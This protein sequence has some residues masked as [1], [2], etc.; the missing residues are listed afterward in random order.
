MATS[1]NYPR[2]TTNKSSGPSSGY[3]GLVRIRSA[4]RLAVIYLAVI[5]VVP[6]S[7][8]LASPFD[9]RPEPS[10]DIEFIG[11]P[12]KAFKFSEVQRYGL[13]DGAITFLKD[14]D[15]ARVWMPTGDGGNSIEVVTDDFRHF[16]ATT[17]PAPWVLSPVPGTFESD[18]TGISKVVRLPTGRLAAIYQA[19]EHPCGPQVAGVSIALATSDDDGRTW[20]RRG[21]IITSPP[22]SRIA[23]D[24]MV[25]HGVWSFAATVEP[26]GEYLYTWFSEGSD[27]QWGDPFGGLRL[28]RAPL[29]GGLLPGTWQKYYNGQWNQPGLGGF[30]SPTL[31]APTPIIS[32]DPTL[33]NEFAGLPSV[34]W[35]TAFNRYVAIFT[36][37]TGFW[38]A[39]SPDGIQWS[40][41]K[42]LLKHKVLITTGREPNEAWVYYPTLIDPQASSD[43]YSATDGILYYAFTPTGTFHEMIGRR[44]RITEAPEVLP[45]TGIGVVWLLCATTLM[46]CFGAIAIHKTRL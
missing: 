2:V 15:Y 5:L 35:N 29:S 13:P 8:A 41:G 42:Q 34:T 40:N 25:F 26:T 19:E 4:S 18:Y 43:G 32:I 27:E 17:T 44:V 46:M 7:G 16:R 14:G 6:S 21:Q 39:T 36:T 38:Y 37:M 9:N 33:S 28:A 11:K 31:V 24:D 10:V 23:C 22:I 1:L 12:F 20:D 3:L 30:T 45:P